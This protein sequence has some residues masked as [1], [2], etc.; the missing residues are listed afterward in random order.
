MAM[1]CRPF[2][3]PALF[4]VHLPR[5]RTRRHVGLLRCHH[6]VHVVVPTARTFAL[7]YSVFVVGRQSLAANSESSCVTGLWLWHCA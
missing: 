3:L 5:A 2:I 1:I 4:L 7:Y 6:A